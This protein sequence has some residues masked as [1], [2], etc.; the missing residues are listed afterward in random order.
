MLIICNHWTLICILKSLNDLIMF[1]VFMTIIFTCIMIRSYRPLAKKLFLNHVLLWEEDIKETL[2]ILLKMFEVTLQLELSG[3]K[4]ENFS[5]FVEQCLS[6]FISIRK[7]L[8]RI[9]LWFE[10]NPRC[11]H[12]VLNSCFFAREWFRY[13][14]Y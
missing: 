7:V 12:Q 4:E 1:D 14:S 5:K 9:S 6:N 10:N 8:L 2:Y 3:E 11:C 13:I